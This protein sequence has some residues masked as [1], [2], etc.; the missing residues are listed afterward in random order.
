MGTLRIITG[1]AKTGKSRG[2]YEEISRSGDREAI[3]LVPE[4]HTHGATR[5]LCSRCGDRA[6]A[7]A[8]VLS[9]TDLARRV[10]EQAG[11]TAAQ[12]LSDSGRLLL[13]NRTIEKLRGVLSI[14]SS[15]AS[16]PAE[17]ER[18][19]MTVD[20]FKSCAVSPEDITR[21]GEKVEFSAKLTE[22][23]AILEM[24]NALSRE[25]GLSPADRLT[26]TA[27]RLELCDFAR[28]AD[29][30]IDGF[31]DFTYRETVIISLLL[32]RCARMT[33]T[34]TWEPGSEE[35]DAF[36]VPV[37]TWGKLLRL[38]RDLGAEVE[39]K[40]TA[41]ERET[42]ITYLGEYLFADGTGTPPETGGVALRACANAYEECLA[43]AEDIARLVR[44]G[45]RYRDITVAVRQVD[46]Y[47]DLMESALEQFGIPLNVTGGTKVR[48]NPVYTLITGALDTVTGGFEYEDIFKFLKTGLAGLRWDECDRLE[49][50]VLRWKVRG[51][52]WWREE[53]WTLNPEGYGVEFTDASRA[54]LTELNIL[55]ERVRRPF[56]AL[57]EGLSGRRPMR[58]MLRALYE[59]LLD[60]SLPEN[61]E[62][63]AEKFRGTRLG[64]Q[65]A[66]LWGKV[67]TALD[68]CAAIMGDTEPDRSEFAAIF[69][70][71]LAWECVDT[72]PATVDAV[73]LTELSRTG[74]SSPKYMFILGANDTSIPLPA[75]NGGVITET[76]RRELLALGL[77]ILPGA[78]SLMTRELYSVY[79]AVTAAA[80]SLTISW[81]ESTDSGTE[82][83]PSFI[84]ERVRELLTD[85]EERRAAGTLSL[86]R[87]LQEGARRLS[88][89]DG[90]VLDELERRGADPA[91]VERVRHAGKYSRGQLTSEGVSALYGGRFDMSASKIDKFN[92]CKFM[93]FM[94]YGLRAKAR[95]SAGFEA[96]EMGTFVHEI[97]ENTARDVEKRGGFKTVEP[98][99]V[100]A[101]AKGHVEHYIE[102]TLGSF[103]DKTPRFRYLFNRL[104]RSV[105]AVAEDMAAELRVSDFRPMEFELE[106]GGKGDL[107]PV[108]RIS[109]DGEIRISGFVD[110]VDGW[111]KDGKLYLR[112]VDYKTGRKKFDFTDI[113]NGLGLQM[114]IY[115]FALERGGKEKFGGDIAPAGVL[116]VPARDVTVRGRRDLPG[117]ERRRMVAKELRRSGVVLDDEDVVTAMENPQDGELRF[118]PVTMK[119]GKI[120]GEYLVS[121]ERLGRLERHIDRVLMEMLGELSSGDIA[122]DPIKKGAG[123]PCDYCDFRQACLFDE[124]ADVPRQAETIKTNDFWLKLGGE[125]GKDG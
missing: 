55:R 33:V 60:I 57:R 25:T 58:N 27:Q 13:M 87:A 78:H 7:Y 23:A 3:I 120:T 15:A 115:L 53:G 10:F 95:K 5:D 45:A 81:S 24:F 71:V 29:I 99:T 90:S 68:Q 108:A 79:S 100:R 2:I 113:A 84:V 114:L 61:L 125:E 36:A 43:A 109:Q 124:C 89:G 4:Q 8:Q 41:R 77:E 64:E 38:G 32:E 75:E 11:G 40:T 62:D 112:V 85:W 67:V 46:E 51:S 88:I 34:L 65:Y 35:S 50:Y 63:K 42:D 56:T 59:F 83:R 39:L 104:L 1:G 72:I 14:Y 110:R 82:L 106:F 6:A 91:R 44:A 103:R 94:E 102:T 9:F 17:L 123:T 70:G 19:L 31:S 107:P 48:A 118:L 30:Y 52:M 98:E 49:N 76:E 54:A 22:L 116:Y 97:L 26:M 117:E 119:N 69:P 20:E 121:A 37:S 92:S 18:L 21:M 96:P 28:G 111:V 122:A 16:K 80:E 105:Y 12:F 86:T 66:Q 73:Q 93:Y 101:I 47:S 74:H